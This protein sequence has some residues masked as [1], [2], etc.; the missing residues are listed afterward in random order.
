ME[1]TL[2]DIIKEKEKWERKQNAEYRDVDKVSDGVKTELFVMTMKIGEQTLEIVK[3]RNKVTALE[4]IL[5]EK[6]KENR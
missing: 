2:E 3:L 4:E 6:E 1:K 5:K